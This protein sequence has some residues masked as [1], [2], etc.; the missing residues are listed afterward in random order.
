MKK[1]I[2]TSYYLWFDTEFTTLDYDQ[3]ELMEVALVITDPD[4]H[5]IA[6]KD[7]QAYVRLEN[8]TALSPWVRENLPATVARCQE[9]LAQPVA[10]VEAA[11]VAY[12]ER[13]VGAVPAEIEK[14]PV[15][16]G[17]SLQSDWLMARKY[18]PRFVRRLHYR[19][20][21]VT[22][23]KL[24]W[25]DYFAGPEFDKE[26]ATIVQKYCPVADIAS[27]LKEHDALYDVFASIAELNYYRQGLCVKN[28]APS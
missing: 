6:D 3:A 8:P 13:W 28:Q 25:G 21:D 14:R 18:L 11:L 2:R 5:R 4:L 24:L 15:L 19:F 22:A 20:L 27:G 17:N 26:N 23:L 1:H 16:A 12:L 9:P 7:F 10:A